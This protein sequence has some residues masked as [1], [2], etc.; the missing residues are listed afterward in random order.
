MLRP[1][2]LRPLYTSRRAIGEERQ[3]PRR[4]LMR[5]HLLFAR[6]HPRPAVT[7]AS[8]PS[9]PGA[10]RSSAPRMLS[11]CGCILLGRRRGGGAGWGRRMERDDWRT[12]EEVG[13]GG[14]ETGPV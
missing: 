6:R 11:R 8:R 9:P 5:P 2:Q 14:G 1:P 7:I 12:G 13:I 4:R 3:D 10:P